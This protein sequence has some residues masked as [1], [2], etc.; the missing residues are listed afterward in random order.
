MAVSI[1]L[2]ALGVLAC[3]IPTRRAMRIDP[4]VALR[5]S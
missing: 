3:A 5:S 2:V 1:L 4:A